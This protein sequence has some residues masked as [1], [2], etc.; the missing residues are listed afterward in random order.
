MTTLSSKIAQAS[1]VVGALK[2]DKR[3]QSQNY[4]YISADKILERVG[5]ALTEVGVVVF[6]AITSE[7]TAQ[8]DYTDSYGKNKSRFDAVVF[9]RMVVADDE[10]ERELPWCGRGTDFASPDKALYKA[11]T[12]G[13]KYFL[14]KL[15]NVG[16]GNEDGEHEVVEDTPKPTQ[17]PQKAQ[18]AKKATMQGNV[19]TDSELAILGA[20]KTPQDAQGWAVKV[21]ACGNEFEAKQSFKKIVDANGGRLTQEN[22]AAVYLAFLRHQHEKLGTEAV[23]A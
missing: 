18:D 20:W 15:L 16:V 7:N 2:P 1:R 17:T 4:D 8:V 5:D 6:P 3:N 13:H 19:P 21:G 23:A 10:S 12:S 14:M 11:I 22:V 9:F